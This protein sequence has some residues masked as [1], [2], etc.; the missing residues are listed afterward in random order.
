MLTGY[1]D[2]TRTSSEFEVRISQY[3]ENKVNDTGAPSIEKQR[4]HHRRK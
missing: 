4:K 1:Q 2:V 3:I